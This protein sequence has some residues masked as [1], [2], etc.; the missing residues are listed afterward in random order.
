MFQEFPVRIGFSFT[1]LI[2]RSRD[3]S[4]PGATVT[5]ASFGSIQWHWRATTAFRLTN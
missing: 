5:L 4:M 1:V 3:T 2:A